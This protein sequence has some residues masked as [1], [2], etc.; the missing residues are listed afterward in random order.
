MNVLTHD[1][2]FGEHKMT[3]IALYAYSIVIVSGVFIQQHE[4]G[5]H[6]LLYAS[7]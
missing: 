1:C 6:T 2:G 7:V 4:G 3:I 5:L